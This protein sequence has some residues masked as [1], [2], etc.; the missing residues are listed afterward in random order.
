MYTLEKKSVPGT[1][2]N[3]IRTLTFRTLQLRSTVYVALP[4]PE[5]LYPILAT[6]L[7]KVPHIIALNVNSSRFCNLVT[8]LFFCNV[9]P[10]V[11]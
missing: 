5:Q 11:I 3:T 10:Y 4:V 2:Y 8:F 9:C 1:A 6:P 7:Y